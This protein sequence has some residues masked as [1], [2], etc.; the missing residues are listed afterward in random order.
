MRN[1]ISAN[2]LNKKEHVITTQIKASITIKFPEK[3]R[4]LVLFAPRAVK[5][6]PNNEFSYSLESCKCCRKQWNLKQINS[7]VRYFASHSVV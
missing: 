1:L 5:C 2:S 7:F 4:P 6:V 3:V